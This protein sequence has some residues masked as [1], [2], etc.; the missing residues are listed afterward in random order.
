MGRLLQNSSD[1]VKSQTIMK[2][3]LFLL[4]PFVLFGVGGLFGR[5]IREGWLFTPQRS[6]NSPS[7]AFE[8][9]SLNHPRLP[10]NLQ[11]H[12][13]DRHNSRNLHKVHPP[14][15]VIRRSPFILQ[16]MP[17]RKKGQLKPLPLRLSRRISCPRRCRNA[18]HTAPTNPE[19]SKKKQAESEL[20]NG[21]TAAPTTES[22]S[23][24]KSGT[25][26]MDPNWDA[27]KPLLGANAPDWVKV[28]LSQGDEHRFVIA[29]S[30]AT[31]IAQCRE[32]FD[33]MLLTEVQN[34]LDK[35]ILTEVR[36]DQ[37]E[38]LTKKYVEEHMLVADKEFDNVQD[39][40]SELT[41]RF[42]GR[43]SYR[44]RS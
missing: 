2:Y 16:R 11:R 5:R 39:R 10:L 44:S 36:A 21:S 12:P 43:S 37:L 6:V 1:C 31:D 14:N 18:I 33:T 22:L 41:T 28:G 15:Q 4:V 7:F 9:R 34:Y 27:S 17:V 30:L 35:H 20:V 40:P 3:L 8:L 32:D 24:T 42:G 29:S 26:D 13:S 38:S 19:P 25:S 23:A